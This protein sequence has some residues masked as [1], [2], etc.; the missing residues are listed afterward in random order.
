MTRGKEL[1]DGHS[2][3]GCLC[4]LLP[5]NP[6]IQGFCGELGSNWAVRSHFSLNPF[7]STHSKT[8]LVEIPREFR[9]W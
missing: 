7:P 5:S 2:I 9:G 3:S 6:S 8:M 4:H 1:Q